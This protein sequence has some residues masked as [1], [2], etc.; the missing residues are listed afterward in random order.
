MSEKRIST[1]TALLFSTEVATQGLGFIVSIMVARILG[2]ESYGLLSF[3]YSLGV[4][5]IMVPSFGFQRFTVHELARSPE[6]ANSFFTHISLLMW[7]FTLLIAVVPFGVALSGPSGE[8]RLFVIFIIYFVMAAL[9]Y[10]LF[11]C[12]F[13]RASQRI[14]KES[15]LRMLLALMWCATGLAVLFAG[16]GLTT[17]VVWRLVVTLLC[18][19]AAVL[20]L[21]SDYGI[22][23]VSFSRQYAWDIVKRSAPLAVFSMLSS[24][25]TFLNLVLLGM[26]RGDVDAGY[27][28]AAEKIVYLVGMIAA[29]LAWVTLPSL[30]RAWARSAKEFSNVC[31]RIMRAALIIAVPC[32]VMVGLLRKTWIFLLFGTG[33][34]PSIP[35]LGILALSIIPFFLSE[36][37]STSLIAMDKQNK[38]V[39]AVLIGLIVLI[40][41]SFILI[42]LWGAKGIALARTFSLCVVIWVQL[43]ALKDGV[44]GKVQWVTFGRVLA[45]GAAMA[46]TIMVLIKLSCT[47]P[48]ALAVS[49]VLYLVMLVLMREM[50]YG[51]ITGIFSR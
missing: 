10:V 29:S 39:R 45:A 21:R 41:S 22:R 17:F 28:S 48:V 7:A 12:S 30:S 33:Y 42:P 51:E 34:L 11:L 36:I 20:V 14:S 24:A 2:V 19:A 32:A 27:Y 1:N 46:L 15:M 37:N 25:F 6:Q 43:R 4:L 38:A 26:M 5:C 16:Y 23:I 47:V 31:T 8:G 35:V 18:V 13:Y 9:E 40:V 44:W 50:R 49:F 3:A